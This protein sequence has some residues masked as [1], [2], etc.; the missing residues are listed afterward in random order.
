MTGRCRRFM[1][2]AAVNRPNWV[3]FHPPVRKMCRGLFMLPI[4][5]ELYF[6]LPYDAAHFTQLISLMEM[7]ENW[8]NKS[9]SCTPKQFV[10]RAHGVGTVY[11]DVHVIFLSHSC[12]IKSLFSESHLAL[13]SKRIQIQ[14]WNT[15]FSSSASANSCNNM[16]YSLTGANYHAFNVTFKTRMCIMDCLSFLLLY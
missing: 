12:R 10:P 11:T 15:D 9:S 3:T 6:L 5:A 8:T 13:K 1:F 16:I 4:W 7:K 14:Q 2:N